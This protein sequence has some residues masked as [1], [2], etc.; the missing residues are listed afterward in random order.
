MGWKT[1]AF[2]TLVIGLMVVA[3]IFILLGAEGL[4][5]TQIDP[6]RSR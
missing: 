1:V 6:V 5:A 4:A 2:Y 3:I